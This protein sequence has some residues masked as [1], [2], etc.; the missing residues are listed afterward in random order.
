[1]R[2][3]GEGVDHSE[4]KEMV[5]TVGSG[6][7]GAPELE[8]LDGGEGLGVVDKDVAGDPA[9]VGAARLLEDAESHAHVGAADGVDRGGA[10]VDLLVAAAVIG[11]VLEQIAVRRYAVPALFVPESFEHAFVERLVLQILGGDE[12]GCPAAVQDA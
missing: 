4:A 7:A 9:P 1:M 5:E 2:L 3:A 10:V 11:V 12:K 8:P 6:K